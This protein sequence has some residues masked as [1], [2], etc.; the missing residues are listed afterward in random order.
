MTFQDILNQPGGKVN[1]YLPLVHLH[2]LMCEARNKAAVLEQSRQDKTPDDRLMIKW[3]SDLADS[4]ARK[5]HDVNEH[6]V[7]GYIYE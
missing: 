7:E 2:E 5:L 6:S 1:R 3:F 4:A